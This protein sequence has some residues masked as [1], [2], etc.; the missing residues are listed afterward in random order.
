MLAS[1]A[2]TLRFSRLLLTGAAGGLGCELR[3]RLKTYCNELRLSDIHP[4]KPPQAQAGEDIQLCPLQDEAAVMALVQGVDAIVHMGGV[5]TEQPW[6]PIL[7]ANIAGVVNLY[8]AARRHGVRV[9]GLRGTA[10][11]DDFGVRIFGL[12]LAD[13]LPCLAGRFRRH[14]T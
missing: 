2:T 11:H 10:R 13:R 1:P 14:R 7:A 5:S 12:G 6:A 9:V 3:A 8:E 4:L